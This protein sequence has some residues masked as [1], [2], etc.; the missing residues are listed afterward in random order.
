MKE[1]SRAGCFVSSPSSPGGSS[2]VLTGSR[3]GANPVQLRF[4]INR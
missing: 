4:N 2:R 1:L 3:I